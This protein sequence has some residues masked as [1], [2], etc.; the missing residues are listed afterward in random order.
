MYSSSAVKWALWQSSYF[1]TFDPSQWCRWKTSKHMKP[2]NIRSSRQNRQN[3]RIR[4][5]KK[6]QKKKNRSKPGHKYTFRPET[7]FFRENTNSLCWKVLLLRER[8][9]KKFYVDWAVCNVLGRYLSVFRFLRKRSK[10]KKTKKKQKKKLKSASSWTL[11]TRATKRI[12][13]FVNVKA[14]KLIFTFHLSFLMFYL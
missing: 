2:K 5:V 1:L 6:K 4:S 11:N 3:C 14:G 10:W 12:P 7:E 8:E 9:K 13:V